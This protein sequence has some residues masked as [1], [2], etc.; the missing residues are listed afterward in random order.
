MARSMSC[1]EVADR[2]GKWANVT[3]VIMGV[4]FLILFVL[5]MAL[6][7]ASAVALADASVFKGFAI[8]GFKEIIYFALSLGLFLAIVSIFGAL[9]YFTLNKTMLIIFVILISIL[10][11]LQIACGGTAFAYRNDFV[12]V[13]DTAWHHAENTTRAYFEDLYFCCGGR[14]ITDFAAKTDHCEE[15]E[16]AD[17]GLLFESEASSVSHYTKGCVEPLAEEMEKNIVAV[18]VGDIVIT[19]LE[20][21]VIIVTL[22]ILVKIRKAYSYQ[23]FKDD[24]AI[25]QLRD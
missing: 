13:T 14:N 20:V 5:G 3:K 21:I 18:G 17:D 4:C 11:I 16:L 23:R 2:V 9:G 12:N 10:A 24:S 1:R 25:E 8:T 19:L 7:I 15:Y 22:I 6:F